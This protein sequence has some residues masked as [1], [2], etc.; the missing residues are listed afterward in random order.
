MLGVALWNY[1]NGVL[2]EDTREKYKPFFTQWGMD[3]IWQ[4]GNMY[5]VP[6]TYNFPDAVASDVGVTLE[7]RTARNT[8]GEPGR[9]DVVGFPV[10]FYQS[11]GLWYGDLTINTFSETYT[12]FVRLALVRYQPHALADAKVSRVVL[13]DFAQLTPDRSAMVTSDPHHPR[14]LRVVVSGVAP[15]GPRAVVRS[16]PRPQE[17]SKRPTQ[18]RV[19]VQERD[20][21]IKSD[22]TWRDVAPEVATVKAVFDDHIGSQP[23]LELW[24][25]TVT[26]AQTP[27]VGRFR[28]LIEEHEYIS[29]NY[30]LVEGRTARQAGRLIYAES[31]ELDDALISE[32]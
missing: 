1:Q 27:E 31:F 20:S 25:G 18:I 13:A 2:N 9:I 15:R 23:D 29:S 17:I 22:L 11:R 8:K 21:Q 14:T 4:T 19:R 16:E 28:L 30:S 26:F 32:T 10:E 3:P 12:P 7:E 6:A 24:A 5:G